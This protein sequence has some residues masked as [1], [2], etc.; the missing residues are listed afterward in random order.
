VHVPGLLAILAYARGVEREDP[1]TG[2]HLPDTDEF[3]LDVI[4]DVPTVKGLQL[5]VRQAWVEAG[6]PD[7]GYQIRFIVNWEIDLL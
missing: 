3:D 5:R 4:Y 7:N 2:G 6:G 1:A